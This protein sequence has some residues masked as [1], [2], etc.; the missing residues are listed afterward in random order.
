MYAEGFRQL[1]L[2]LLSKLDIP[3]IQIN[4]ATVLILQF[5]VSDNLYS[6]I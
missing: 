4:V 1:G 6:D 2:T 3:E 5:V